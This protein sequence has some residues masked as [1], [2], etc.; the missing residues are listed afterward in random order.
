MNPRQRE[1]EV[2]V[3][4]CM[5]LKVQRT[6][7]CDCA[8][9]GFLNEMHHARALPGCQDIDKVNVSQRLG[10]ICAFL[11]KTL[12]TLRVHALK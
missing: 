11:R 10:V 1:R 4:V 6:W 8:D 5:V 7:F 2:T 9:R 3:Y 12:K